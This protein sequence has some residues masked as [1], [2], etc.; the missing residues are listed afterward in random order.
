MTVGTFHI[1]VGHDGTFYFKRL[2]KTMT[3]NSQDIKCK[4]ISE[5]DFLVTVGW[6]TVCEMNGSTLDP[7]A[8]NN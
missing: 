7:G 1:R 8:I 2:M 4:Q 6:Y 3:K 5:D